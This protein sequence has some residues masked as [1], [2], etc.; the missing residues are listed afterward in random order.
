[1]YIS[2]FT[3]IIINVKWDELIIYLITT[4][5]F[6]SQRE[7]IRFPLRRRNALS[8]EEIEKILKNIKDNKKFIDE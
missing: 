7:E 4:Q 3:S 8:E 2:E 6:M 1:M 5:F